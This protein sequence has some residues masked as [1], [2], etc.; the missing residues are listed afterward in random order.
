MLACLLGA[1]GLAMAEG[2]WEVYQQAKASDPQLRSAGFSLEAALQARPKA[3]AALLPS[4]TAS[5]SNG[6]NHFEDKNPP[7][8]PKTGASRPNQDYD[9]QKY[10]VYLTQP[11]VNL[12][13]WLGLSQAGQRQDE[14]QATYRANLGEFSL[15]FLEVYLKVVGAQERLNLV[16]AEKLAIAQSLARARR[17][18]ELGLISATAELRAQASHD[19]AEADEIAAENQLENSLE[20]LRELTGRRIEKPGH[21]KDNLEPKPP[22]PNDLSHWNLVATKQNFNLLAKKHSLESARLEINRQEAGHLPSMNLVASH[23]YEDTGGRVPGEDTVSSVAL[24]VRVPIFDGW[25]VVANTREARSNH[26]KARE[27]YEAT[28]RQVVKR[29]GEAF[30]GMNESVRR[31]NALKQAVRS[32]SEALLSAQRELEIGSNTMVELLEALRDLYRSRRELSDA[33]SE[34]LLNRVRLLYFAGVLSE[35]D[36]KAISHFFQEDA[37]REPVQSL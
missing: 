9:S 26:S 8:D 1:P 14:A 27:E 19:L 13:S 18:S 21:L 10:G 34:Y 31:V 6:L 15:R 30:R 24:E 36:M 3:M 23:Y 29:T 22:E 20:G 37:A 5:T 35:E 4:L 28:R 11:V 17:A 2:M 25:A 7:V 16:R 12:Q 32:S 33:N